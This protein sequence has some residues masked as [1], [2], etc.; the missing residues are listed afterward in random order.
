MPVNH[1]I[2]R[3]RIKSAL[4]VAA[5][6][7]LLGYALITGLGFQLPAEVT[8]KL[9]V[10]D[11]VEPPPPPEE[12]P[13]PAKVRVEAPEGAASPPSMKANPTPIVAPPPIIKLDVPPPVVSVPVP[14][15]VPTGVDPTAGVAAIPGPGTGT[16]G[17]GNGTGAGGQ[18]S[19]TGGG[20]GSP[21]RWISGRI[22]DSDYPRGAVR[23]RASG[24]VFLRFVVAPTGRVINC[25]ITRSSG[26]RDLD[27]TTCGLIERR[28]RYRPARDPSGRPVADTIAGE[29]VW[30]LG[31][32]PEPIEI[33]PTIP[34]DGPA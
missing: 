27:Q 33:E 2:N 31:P 13:I 5:F 25:R 19:G 8:D 28:F 23:A 32:E 20:G 16:G 21:P 9:Q 26:N 34:D 12:K 30:E 22:M 29:H 7:A 24:T 17:E 1:E 4:G 6:H 18:G 3:D 15:P 11:V 14:T 10:F